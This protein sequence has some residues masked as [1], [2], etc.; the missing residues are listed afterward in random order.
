MDKDKVE[1]FE[2]LRRK[3]MWIFE[4]KG[5]IPSE[6]QQ[7][8][9][10]MFN[11]LAEKYREI[12]C[13]SSTIREYIEGSIDELMPRLQVVVGERRKEE[14]FEGI[15]SFLSG[16]QSELEEKINGEE[17]KRRDNKNRERIGEIANDSPS[18]IRTTLNTVDLVEEALKD[19]KLAQNRALAARGLYS[20]R[21]IYD[22]DDEIT[23]FIMKLRSASEGEIHEGYQ[24]D[25]SQLREE[26]LQA[27]EEYVEE[28]GDEE[29]DK[30]KKFKDELSQG[31]P[32]L[33]EQKRAAIRRELEA[34]FIGDKNEQPQLGSL[35][36]KFKEDVEVAK[37]TEEDQLPDIEF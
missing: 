25:N 26:L 6:V 7:T 11:K 22:I 9:Q 33:E 27:F 20:D 2:E 19:V 5:E 31:M 21:Q 1:S 3:M 10:Q 18:N 24:A 29:P 17:Q 32:S 37:E 28:R 8:I 23:S 34:L 36:D 14:Q 16:V 35:A 13:Y 30:A 15:Q 4:D 12:G